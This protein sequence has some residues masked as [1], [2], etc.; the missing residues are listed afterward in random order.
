M[1]AIALPFYVYDVS[2][3]TVATGLMFMSLIV[4]SILLGSVAGV[5]VDRWDRRRTMLTADILR[6]ATLLPL[7]TVS[8]SESLW[9]VIVVAFSGSAVSQ[10]FVPAENSLLPSLVSEEDLV[11]ANSLNTLNNNIALLAG[12]PLGG[13]LL[14]WL[15]L[16]GVA[17]VDAASL[18][19]SAL[20]IGLIRTPSVEKGQTETSTAPRAA[21]VRFWSEWL[22]GLRLVREERW[23]TALFAVTGIVM[24]G[25]GIEVVLLVAFVRD[26]L[27]A[28][29]AGYGWLFTAYA[30]GG[31]IGGV[32]IAQAGKALRAKHLLGLACLAWGLIFLVIINIPSFVLALALLLVMGVP[33]VGWRVGR[34]SLLQVGVPDR[35]RGRIFG[36][37]GATASL[38]LLTAEG[39]AAA[40]GETLGVVLM[41][42]VAAVLYT[43][44]GVTALLMLPDRVPQSESARDMREASTH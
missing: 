44:A 2:G 12:A 25:N 18:L 7:L 8:S 19:V 4:P 10:F 31:L 40:L 1:L 6:A 33:G 16:P 42:N 37:L 20:L 23:I 15:G 22:E 3:S 13:L 29:S 38:V 36:A 32:I 17:L 34:Q 14:A 11:A 5:F 28:G 35:Y 9:L 21:W 26:V 24:L 27:Q 30:V 41:L 43:S 39:I